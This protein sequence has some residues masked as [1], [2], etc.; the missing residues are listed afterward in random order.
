M[1]TLI[2]VHPSVL[3]FR[4]RF[5]GFFLCCTF[6]SCLWVVIFFPLELFVSTVSSVYLPLNC[7][8]NYYNQ[9]SE[10]LKVE[11]CQHYVWKS[12]ILRAKNYGRYQWKV[13]C[14]FIECSERRRKAACAVGLATV[15]AAFLLPSLK[16][17]GQEVI[18]ICCWTLL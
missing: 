1:K 10:S 4:S 2:K 17:Q 11:C 13:D 7:C 3:V 8:S 12:N 15:Q 9:P 5:H 14:D 6:L 18:S 16:L